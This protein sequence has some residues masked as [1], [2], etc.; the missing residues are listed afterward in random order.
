MKDI[1]KVVLIIFLVT[2][3]VHFCRANFSDMQENETYISTADSKIKIELTKEDEDILDD[4]GNVMV[5]QH[6]A[7]LH[8]DGEKYQG[9][10]K[11]F[12]SNKFKKELSVD[13][14]GYNVSTDNPSGLL[15][16]H[17]YVKRNKL[18][19]KDIKDYY[20]SKGIFKENNTFIRKTWWNTWGKKV[21]I[22]LIILFVIWLL[23]IPE[24]LMNKKYR[25]ETINDFKESKREYDKEKEEM[26]KDYYEEVSGYKELMKEGV[27]EMK[28]GVEEIKDVLKKGLEE[29][30]NNNKKN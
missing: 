22:I 19:V 27:N 24:F 13:F 17:F 12:V 7:Y 5:T 18:V 10:Y 6:I 2:F 1:I 20:T 30:K 9:T 29:Y 8:I 16:G 28:E 21:I 23:R 15:L 25:E 26:L 4:Y 14:Y 11:L 3:V